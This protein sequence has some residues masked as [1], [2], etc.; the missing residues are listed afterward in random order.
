MIHVPVR[1]IERE[2][3]ILEANNKVLCHLFLRPEDSH[4]KMHERGYEL[5]RA[6]NNGFVS[7]EK[8]NDKTFLSQFNFSTRTLNSLTA[9]KIM[10]IADLKQCTEHELLDLDNFGDKCLAEVK[11]QLKALKLELKK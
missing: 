1:Y 3:L 8:V 7:G 10:T 4:A 2:V 9:K 6:I 11:S 5:E